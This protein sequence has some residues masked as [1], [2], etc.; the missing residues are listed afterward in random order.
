MSFQATYAGEEILTA[1]WA[2]PL[3]DATVRADFKPGNLLRA[4]RAIDVP[5]TIVEGVSGCGR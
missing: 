1:T 4:F 2:T 5:R 3:R